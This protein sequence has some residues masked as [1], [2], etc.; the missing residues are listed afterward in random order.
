MRRSI[1]SLCC[2]IAPLLAGCLAA[3]CR[4]QDS[5]F[6]L[7]A[8]AYN[9]ATAKDIG[10]PEYPGAKPYKEKDSDSSSAD[11]GLVLNSFHFSVRAASYVTADSPAQVLAFYRGPLSKYG[12]VLECDHGKPVGALTVAKSG[13]TC[14]DQQSGHTSVNGSDDDHQLRAGTP[15][16]FR[17]VGIDTTE[18]GQTKFGLVALEIPKQAQY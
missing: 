1:P 18:A 2:L 15:E 7:S 4:A 9:H 10:L 8:H 13:L 17:V 14:G 16:R 12:D 11:L 5:G 6:N 3:S